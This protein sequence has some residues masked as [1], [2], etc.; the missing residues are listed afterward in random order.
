MLYEIDGKSAFRIELYDH[1]V[2]HKWKKLI[3]STYV[4]DGNDIDHKRT[5]FHLQTRKEIKDILLRAIENINKFLKK[6]FIQT[7]NIDWNNQETYN[8]LHLAFEKLAGEFDN[9][10]RLMKIAPDI[11][12]ESVK[13]LNYC[14][15]ALEHEDQKPQSLAIQW[16]KARTKMPRFKLESYEYNLFQFNTKQH[17][18]YLSYNE[19]GKT[20]KDLYVDQL[21]INYEA[22]KNKH[23]IGADIEIN[24][25]ESKDIFDS[26]FVSWC[27]SNTIDPYMKENALGKLPIGKCIIYDI[28]H[29]TKDSKIDIIEGV[30]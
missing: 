17:E 9:P 3:D 30:K 16:T 12:K 21:P 10:T 27:K 22:T 26:K 24:L 20:Y 6:T 25:I 23:F 5:F 14:V 28:E 8:T 19:L 2:A 13:D 4:G 1:S 15:H 7:E 18:V 11:V 29:L